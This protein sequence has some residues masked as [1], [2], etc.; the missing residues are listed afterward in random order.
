MSP[1]SSAAAQ[2]LPVVRAEGPAQRRSSPRLR[3]VLYGVPTAVLG[4]ALLAS[5]VVSGP[6]A[7]VLAALVL[8]AVPSAAT[9]SRRVAVTGALVVGWV[10]VVWWVRWPV[11]VDHGAAVVAATVGVLAGLVGGSA[12]PSARARSLVPRLQRADVLLVLA[13]VG[14]LFSTSRWAFA[15]SAQAALASL[16]PG[17]DNFAHFSM[18]ALLRARGA[19]PEVLG[20]GPDGS[21]WAYDNYPKGFHSLAATLSEL[22]VPHL[23]TGPGS[24]LAYTHA[25]SAVVVLGA[26][27]LTAT[28]L[29]LPGLAARP[30]VAAPAVVL[31]LTAF[32]WEPGQKVLADGFASFWLGALAASC[33][34]LLSIS[35]PRSVRTVEL[36]AIGGLLVCVAH[37]WTPLLLIGGPAMLV[38]FRREDRSVLTPR[39]P[40]R[41]LAQALVLLVTA[42]AGLKAV[43]VLLSTVSVGYL[44]SAAGGQHGTS[45]LPTF[46]LL[47]VG[48]YVVLTARSWVRSRGVTPVDTRLLQHR[49]AIP[50]V[51]M[52]TGVASLSV[53][54]VEQMRT[55]G[56]TSYYFFKYLLGFELILAA[57]VPALCASLVVVVTRPCGRRMRGRLASVLVTLLATQAFGHLS[58]DRALLFSAGDFGTAQVSP[59]YNRAGIAHGVLAAASSTISGSVGVEYVPLGAGAAVQAFYPDAWYH[60]VSVS[61]TRRAWSRLAVLRHHADSPEAAAALISQLMTSDQSLRV[62]VDPASV[63]VLRR[64]VGSA[65][66]AR[67]VLPWASHESPSPG[68][69]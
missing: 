9:L 2:V 15:G 12:D 11:P 38:I 34:L 55:L 60:A 54:L 35:C 24:V 61:L 43:V 66:L 67:R 30:A 20:R 50:A 31:T 33:A 14:A 49:I 8:A 26:L 7:L 53:L 63:D 18:F 1:A 51:S 42:A 6:L 22:S 16:V 4:Y 58:L 5:G 52:A 13:A 48:G 3:G 69:R 64:G 44:V 62:L 37:T 45:P 39:R 56:T 68:G 29:S 17:A 41:R 47:V 36:A 19:V 27:V 59:P 23:A 65:S 40:H 28:F 32:L 57:L 25:V 21:G 46:L 10:P